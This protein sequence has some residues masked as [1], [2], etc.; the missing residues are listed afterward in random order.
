M[1]LNAD[2]SLSDKSQF[3]SMVTVTNLVPF[4]PNLVFPLDQFNLFVGPNGAG[5]STMLRTLSESPALST[6]VLSISNY[7]LPAEKIL[8]LEE[9]LVRPINYYPDIEGLT[10]HLKAFSNFDYDDSEKVKEIQRYLEILFNRR[11]LNYVIEN[12]NRITGYRKNNKLKIPIECDGLGI[13][14]I[15][16]TLEAAVYLPEQS[17]LYIEDPTMGVS[18]SIAWEFLD[19]LCNILD[20]KK[21]ILVATTQDFVCLLYFIRKMKEKHLGMNILSF[22]EDEDNPMYSIV[23]LIN[24]T[25]LGKFM[26]IFPFISTVVDM[27][28]YNHFEGT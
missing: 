20:K 17:V 9:R 11:V 15:V 1:A 8:L 24:E 23:E 19:I 6:S 12:G 5:K 4:H 27:A 2:D 3:Q 26:G 10:N 16:T 28:D 22:R 21:S 13:K 14:N 18:P 25:N 7:G